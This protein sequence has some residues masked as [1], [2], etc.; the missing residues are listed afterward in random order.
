MQ[1]SRLKSQ[2]EGR[3]APAVRTRIA[4]RQA[5]YRY[6]REEVG[7]VWLTI[8]GV[9]VASFDTASY[10][11]K[12]ADL[13]AQIRDARGLRPYGD[14]GGKA[15]YLEADGEAE[16]ILRRAGEYD[17]YHAIGDLEAF[18]SMS[19]ESALAAASPLVR[20]LAVV[21]AR[22][23]KRRLRGLAATVADEHPLVR[24]LLTLRCEAEQVPIN[25]PAL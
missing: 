22:V 5:R 16:A 1:W 11:T 17:D 7:R 21:D 19:I 18:L 12:R 4:L 24:R 3:F 6:T 23:G 10:V 2:V 20:G 8:D 14:P 13:S 9:E 15:E 25:A